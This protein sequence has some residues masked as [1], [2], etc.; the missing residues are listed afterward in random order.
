V[1]TAVAPHERRSSGGR[2]RPVAARA[3]EWRELR[4]LGRLGAVGLVLSGLVAVI[5]GLWIEGPFAITCSR[6]G[7]N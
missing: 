2:V 6:C 1:A 7:S 4:G 3:I 5:L